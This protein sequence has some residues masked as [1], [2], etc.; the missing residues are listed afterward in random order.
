MDWLTFVATLIEHLAWP[1]AVAALFLAYRAPIAER[2][3][4]LK[5]L[6]YQDLEFDLADQLKELSVKAEQAK[7]SAPSRPTLPPVRSALPASLMEQAK[8]IVDAAPFAAIIVAWSALEQKLAETVTRLAISPDPP[9]RSSAI[10]NVELLQ[11]SERLD[12]KS[13]DLI[14]GLRRIR[15][16]L[17]HP[18]GAQIHIKQHDAEQYISLVED[19]LAFL[20]T[21]QR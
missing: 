10:T 12:K 1:L 21:Q 13:A 19:L 3:R 18:R 4:A 20:E 2:I 6:K 17:A 14:Q 9:S 16:D 7:V 8:S 15:N 5:R 11:A